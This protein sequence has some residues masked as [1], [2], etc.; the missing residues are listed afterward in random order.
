MESM[1]GFAQG[2][3][4]DKKSRIYVKAKSV[5]SRYLDIK[6]NLSSNL[7][8]LEPE[9][10]TLVS[11][12]LNR[13]SVEV[14]VHCLDKDMGSRLKSLK[15]WTKSYKK[16]AHELDVIEDLTLDMV[17]KKSSQTGQNKAEKTVLKEALKAANTVLAGLK[18]EREKEGKEL[19]KVLLAELSNSKKCFD[20]IKTSVLKDRS[21]I[22]ERFNEKLKS[23]NIEIN[24]ERFESEV[25][26]LLDKSDVT[27][28]FDRL[29]VH[30]KEFKNLISSKDSV[31]GKKL[32]FYCQELSREVNTIGSKIKNSTVTKSLVDLK[33]SI[34]TI[35]QQVQ[36][37]Q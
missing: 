4:E 9:L 31:I 5:N 27:E 20:E 12:F 24:Q 32:D 10:R 30:F 6:V 17:I 37:I 33:S 25:A 26:L 23:L 7:S 18:K 16:L 21:K 14:T 8:E 11:K 36:N 1:T 13:G 29:E 35:R 22:T 15:S 28:E 19:K 34:E 3:L 2:E